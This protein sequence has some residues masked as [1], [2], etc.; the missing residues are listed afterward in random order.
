[1]LLIGYLI[2]RYYDDVEENKARE[3]R[4]VEYFR[5]QTFLAE[6]ARAETE[7]YIAKENQRRE[8]GRVEKT[9]RKAERQA[10]KRRT[11][12]RART[13]S[14]GS[15]DGTGKIHRP[16]LSSYG[17]VHELFLSSSSSSAESSSY[18]I[19]SLNS[20]ER[21]ALR[22]NTPHRKRTKGPNRAVLAAQYAY[23]ESQYARSSSSVYSDNSGCGS[24]VRRDNS[25]SGSDSDESSGGSHSQEYSDSSLVSSDDYTND[26]SSTSYE[27]DDS[28][29]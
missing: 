28:R 8:A 1:M 25:S 24:Y 9:L 19:S 5:Q 29:V 6:Q 20:S 26:G 18:A 22:K 27:S 4:K 14:H 16:R 21:R 12:T 13:I 3:R 10:A 23:T 11:R 15:S 7:K 2:Y 17:T